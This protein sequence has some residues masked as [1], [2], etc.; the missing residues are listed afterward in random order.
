MKERLK[1]IIGDLRL[2]VLFP[3]RYVA[4]GTHDGAYWRGM[5]QVYGDMEKRLL[6]SGYRWRVITYDDGHREL[7]YLRVLQGGMLSGKYP[8]IYRGLAIPRRISLETF[9]RIKDIRI[10]F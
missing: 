10:A 9:S 5:T 8:A 3:K 4:R 2:L 6:S 1:D 7:A